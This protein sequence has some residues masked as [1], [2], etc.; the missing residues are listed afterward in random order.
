LVD[1]K[2]VQDLIST[3]LSNFDSVALTYYNAYYVKKMD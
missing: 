3:I 1:L 2:D